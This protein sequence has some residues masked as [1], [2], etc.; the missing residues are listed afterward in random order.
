MVSSGILAAN[1]NPNAVLRR[2]SVG[3]PT[4]GANKGAGGSWGAGAIGV[5]L[6]ANQA[7]LIT[8][9]ERHKKKIV[10]RRIPA[11]KKLVH[12]TPARPS[13]LMADCD[14]VI[15]APANVSAESNRVSRLACTRWRL[16][17]IRRSNSTDRSGF[18]HFP[19]VPEVSGLRA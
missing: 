15:F 14:A 19:D 10:R 12:G 16:P 13:T 3:N 6:V 11:T 9:R 8:C 17:G 1:W 2:L 5:R 7:G 18:H 4:C